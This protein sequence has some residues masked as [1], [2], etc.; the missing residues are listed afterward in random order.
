MKSVQVEYKM[1]DPYVRTKLIKEEG[2]KTFST[3]LRTPDSKNGVFKFLV[4][5]RRLGWSRISLEEVAPN[6]IWRHDEHSRHSIFHPNYMSVLVM[7]GGFF[8]FS[9]FFVFTA[10][11]KEK[12]D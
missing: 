12:K 5:F 4:D 1:L 6:R 3:V 11:S 10:G 2:T 7:I 8:A 9:M